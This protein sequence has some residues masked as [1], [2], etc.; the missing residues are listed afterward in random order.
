M[1]LGMNACWCLFTNYT[2]IQDSERERDL[3]SQTLRLGGARGF[4]G[5]H[6]TCRILILYL[7]EGHHIVI[8]HFYV[9]SVRVF[10]VS[11][12]SFTTLC[13][14]QSPDMT[15]SNPSAPCRLQLRLQSQVFILPLR[16][17]LAL[18]PAPTKRV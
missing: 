7:K 9:K 18:C 3:P 15:A 12:T 5:P 16:S 13:G 10:N 11:T 2:I 14:R 4:F 6:P 8:V 1:P 17:G